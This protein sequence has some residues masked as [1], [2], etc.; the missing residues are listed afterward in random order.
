M[1]EYGQKGILEEKNSQS[2]IKAT[3]KSLR[4]TDKKGS[5]IEK[6]LKKTTMNKVRFQQNVHKCYYFTCMVEDGRAFK[7]KF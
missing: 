7:T 1:I 5:L 2:N 6:M 3:E 4:N